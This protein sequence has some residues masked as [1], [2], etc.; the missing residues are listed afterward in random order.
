MPKLPDGRTY[1]EEREFRARADGK[2]W[3]GRVTIFILR[4][5]KGWKK[6]NSSGWVPVTRRRA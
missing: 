2:G 3:E 1:R 5:T 4:P 6:A